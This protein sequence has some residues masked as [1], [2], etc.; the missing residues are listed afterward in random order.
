MI[1]LLNYFYDSFVF[2]LFGSFSKFLFVGGKTS[3]I[4]TKT[5][6]FNANTV[7]FT[8]SLS[9]YRVCVC[10]V[11]CVCEWVCRSLF[12]CMCVWGYMTVS[13]SLSLSVCIYVCML[14]CVWG[15]LSLSL[16]VSP[17]HTLSPSLLFFSLYVSLS[18][19]FNGPSLVCRFL[20]LQVSLTLS[21]VQ[22]YLRTI[23][24]LK[25]SLKA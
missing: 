15:A 10:G 22:I 1:W 9:L 5:L 17:S 21:F 12:V 4:H 19:L 3:M 14:V 18:Y 6:N 16:Y 24:P 11:V 20:S 7:S 25:K 8:L 13:L 2:Y 23:S